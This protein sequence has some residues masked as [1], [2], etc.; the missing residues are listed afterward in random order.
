[1]DVLN[2]LTSRDPNQRPDFNGDTLIRI[3]I[4]EQ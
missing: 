3:I 1:M 4:E 2:S